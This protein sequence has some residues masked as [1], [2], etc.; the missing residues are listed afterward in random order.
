[1]RKLKLQELN[2]L[3]IKEFKNSKKNPIVL[4]LDNI[5]SLHNVGAFFRTADALRL[6]KLYLTGFTA[7][8]PH[9]E[10]HK[11]ALG[12]T[13][14]VEW[15]YRKNV[16]ELIKELKVE[17]YLV[18]AAEQTDK[19]VMLHEFCPPA[20]KK[21]LVIFGNEVNGIT[22]EVLPLVDSAIEIP[23]FGTKHSFNVSVSAGIVLWDILA[24]LKW[25]K[26]I[27]H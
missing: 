25:Y 1:M 7:T 2:R 11:T 3:G 26:K 22:D 27:C 21:L 18:L 12:A 24:K 8:P 19:S 13:E 17:G 6:E 10:I 9:R 23:Q 20:E 4:I 16:V 15:E 5:R 14:S